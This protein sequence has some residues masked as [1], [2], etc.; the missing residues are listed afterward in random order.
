M[1]DTRPEGVTDDEWQAILAHRRD[2]AP[3]RKATLRGTDPE[4]G[5]EWELELTVEEAA[6][7][8]GKA[9]GKLFDDDAGKKGDDG[10]GK[11]PA[12]LKD[13]FGKKQAAGS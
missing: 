10:K 4:S 3:K 1:A 12:V 6:K 2:S 5:N 13:Y 9:L 7:L 8:A 11:K